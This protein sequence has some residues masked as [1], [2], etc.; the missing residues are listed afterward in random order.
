MRLMS[1]L[2]AGLLRR[3]RGRLLGT[4]GGQPVLLL[5]TTGRRS[6]LE[7]TTP[8]QFQRQGEAFVVVA[9]AGGA[10]HPPA[11]A[12]NLDAHPQ[13]RIQLG[14]DVRR[15]TARRVG[16]AERAERWRELC[17]GNRWLPSVARKA[18]RELGVYVLEP[19]ATDR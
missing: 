13:A 2:H 12:L 6:G 19:A 7:R 9:A 14:S 5:T 17:A 10:P 18:G 1:R 15:V 3:S 11:W 8:V 16:G 4:I